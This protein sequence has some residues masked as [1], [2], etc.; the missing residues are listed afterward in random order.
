VY[1]VRFL[2]DHGARELVDS[3]GNT[4]AHLSAKRGH[5]PTMKLLLERGSD[6]FIRNVSP[7]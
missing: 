5:A 2:L 6:P 3:K 7:S 4:P 1:S